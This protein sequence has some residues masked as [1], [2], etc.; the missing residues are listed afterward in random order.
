MRP[1]DDERVGAQ[2]SDAAVH[3]EYRSFVGSEPRHSRSGHGDELPDDGVD[4][5]RLRRHRGVY[6]RHRDW[7][8][9]RVG[10]IGW[11]RCC[12]WARGYVCDG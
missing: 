12:S 10:G 4:D 3:G 1:W 2:P 7:K 8:A 11:A 5:G 9:H 6:A